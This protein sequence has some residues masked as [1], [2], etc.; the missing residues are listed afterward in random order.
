MIVGNLGFLRNIGFV[1]NSGFLGNL[2]FLGKLVLLQKFGARLK[3]VVDW[4]IGLVARKFGVPL[5]FKGLQKF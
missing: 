1:G 4:I 3:F 2:V 5:K